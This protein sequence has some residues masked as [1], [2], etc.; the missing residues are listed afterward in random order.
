MSEL[1]REYPETNQA[2]VLDG[3]GNL[4]RQLEKPVITKRGTWRELGNILTYPTKKEAQK[5]AKIMGVPQ[6]MVEQIKA[7]M[8]FLPW[9]IRYDFR[10]N[11]Y[12][13]CWDV[14]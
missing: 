4:L 1:F 7:P 9:A 2:V 10:T 8:G 6:N 11:Y 14:S 5:C 3:Q 13:A 12:Y